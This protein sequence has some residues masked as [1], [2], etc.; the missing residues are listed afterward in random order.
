VR[1]SVYLHEGLDRDT[2]RSH[3]SQVTG[4][5]LSQFRPGVSGG[6]RQQHLHQQT[7]LRLCARD[8][9]L[10]GHAPSDHGR[11]GSFAIVGLA[12]SGVAQS[13]ERMAVNH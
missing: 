4:V 10:H 11:D 6:R 1:I 9:Q 2:A 13:A 12:Q 8:L 7:S 3:W 5:P